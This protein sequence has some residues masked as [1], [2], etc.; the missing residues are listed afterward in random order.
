[1]SRIV[2]TFQ[3]G[4]LLP[5]FLEEVDGK[6]IFIL[7][8]G[9]RKKNLKVFARFSKNVD[10]DPSTLKQ[11]LKEIEE[12]IKKLEEEIDDQLIWEIL[13]KDASIDEI[14]ELFFGE[15]V[16]DERKVALFNKLNASKFFKRKGEIFI[17]RTKEELKKIEKMEQARLEK[18][19]TAEEFIQ[20]V[21][22][23]KEK[24]ENIKKTIQILKKYIIEDGNIPQKNVVEIVMEKAEIKNKYGLISL[25][26]RIGEWSVEEEPLMEKL[27]IKKPFKPELI[28]EGENV[29]PDDRE[30]VEYGET[31]AIDDRETVEVDDSFSIEKKG[32]NYLI[33]IHVADLSSLLPRDSLIDKEAFKRVQ[34]VYLPEEKFFMLPKKLI[35]EKY[36]LSEKRSSRA[37]SL[38]LEIDPEF[39]ILNWWFQR[40]WIKVKR[41]TYEESQS[42][43]QGIYSVLLEFLNYRRSERIERG[44]I[45]LNIPELEIKI[46]GE[47]IEIIKKEFNTPAHI[48]VQEAMILYNEKAAEFLSKAGIPAIYRIQPSEFE[49]K[50]QIDLTDPLYPIKAI[51]YLKSSHLTTQ[52]QP[53]L[54]LGVNLYTQATSPIR[55]YG[56]LVIQRQ[57]LKAMGIEEWAYEREELLSIFD[58]LEEKSR[59]I[60]ELVKSRKVFWI[61]KYL[62]KMKGRHIEGY[63]SRLKDGRHM[64]FFPQFMLELPVNL[65]WN[66]AQRPGRKMVFK[67]K[68]VDIKRRRPILVPV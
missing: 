20:F 56:D 52:P 67:I 48:A 25:L 32:N 23:K 2:F 39:R 65:R 30:R 27:S 6:V 24:D 12:E 58:Y 22:G 10:Y 55:R 29:I 64:I 47:E 44:A 46:K 1:M 63:Y 61:M 43:F 50:P 15:Q 49:E 14:S 38:F 4:K 36:T 26:E 11:N 8:S 31:I 7:P 62:E 16:A 54:S 34:T 57:I 41:K 40:T 33:G 18:E 59:L 28:I 66:R 13:D 21:K 53:H 37:L 17:K 45:V 5:V 9:K 19:K 35:E 3:E 42:I 60:R 68:E 51:P